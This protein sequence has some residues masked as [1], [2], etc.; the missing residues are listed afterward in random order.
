[1][2]YAS[3]YFVDAYSGVPVDPTAP[4]SSAVI[5]SPIQVN[6]TVFR[7][8]PSS[9]NEGMQTEGGIMQKGRIWIRIPEGEYP[10]ELLASDTVE[11]NGDRFRIHRFFKDG[12]S[13]GP[14]RLYVEA[15]LE[16]P[17]YYDVQPSGGVTMSTGRSRNDYI[18]DGLAS[19][20]TLSTFFITGTTEVFIDGVLQTAGASSDYIE[21]PPNQVSFSYSPASGQLVSVMFSP[22]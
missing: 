11:V 12:I 2:A 20:F 16:F 13:D 17:A 14:D 3:T 5:Y 21:A 7:R 19:S 9:P 10:E 4:L 6:A 15:E 22:A 18:A 8:N 1:V